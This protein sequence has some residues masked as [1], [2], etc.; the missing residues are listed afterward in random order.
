MG[1]SGQIPTRAIESGMITRLGSIDKIEGGETSRANLYLKHVHEFANGAYLSQQVYGVSYDFNL[2]SNFTF[3]LNDPMH[4]DQIEQKESRMIYG[5]KANYNACGLVFGKTLKTEIGA[6]VRLDDVNNIALSHSVKRE[7][8]NDIK[9]GDV[10]ETNFNAYLNE[11]FSLTEKW[12]VNA[13]LRLDYFDFRYSD[14]LANT[15]KSSGKTVV[16]PKLNINYQLN[17]NTQIYLRTGLGFHFNDARVAIAQNGNDFVPRAYGVDLGMN[18]KVTEKLLVNVA[19]WRLD[20]NQE[21]VYVGDEGIVEPRGKTKR[22]GIDLSLRY[23]VLPW[24]FVDGDLNLTKPEAKSEVE[25]MN[26]I[27]LAPTFPVSG[28]YPSG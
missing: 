4:G 22:E 25:G 16:S 6:G 19:F 11:T 23:Q 26:Y 12:S 28:D 20:L 27:P 7:L 1:R 18:S 15:I 13:A 24:L 8:L 3:Y 17:P 10:N 14:K 2:F 5:Y 9:R 21:F